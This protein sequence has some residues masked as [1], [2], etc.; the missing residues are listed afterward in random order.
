MTDKAAKNNFPLIFVIEDNE[1]FLKMIEEHLKLN[2]LSNI[3]SFTNGEDCL[4]YLYYKPDIIIL[5]YE[6][7][8]INGIEMLKKI[9]KSIPEVYVY[10]PKVL[11]YDTKLF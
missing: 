4:Q 6:L 2:N 9:K 7:T 10:S 11:Q 5:D 8:D 3:K 1:L